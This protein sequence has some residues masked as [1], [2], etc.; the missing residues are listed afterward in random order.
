MAATLVDPDSGRNITEFTD[1][2]VECF[3]REFSHGAILKSD[4]AS[5]R[6]AGAEQQ[7]VRLFA[8]RSIAAEEVTSVVP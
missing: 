2:E 8:G 5:V 1:V 7:T 3:R 4:L 6:V